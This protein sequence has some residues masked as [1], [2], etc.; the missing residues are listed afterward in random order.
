MAEQI[1]FEL[2][3][4]EEKLVS[5]PVDMAVIPGAEGELGVMAGHSSFVVALKPGLVK[6]KTGG[7]DR[8]IFIAGGFAD[9]TGEQVTVLAEQ[10]ANVDNLDKAAAQQKI[11]NL[12]ED[13]DR[14]DTEAAKSRIRA[15]LELEKA[16][17]FAITGKLPA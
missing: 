5:E 11:A 10:A 16:K 13:L 4:P 7:K 9:I 12:E 8:S 3:S 14:A 6:L 17:I 2:V 15:A 1:H